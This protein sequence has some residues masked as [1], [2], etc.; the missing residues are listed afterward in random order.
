[1]ESELWET[2]DAKVGEVLQ[3]LFEAYNYFESKVQTAVKSLLESEDFTYK[4]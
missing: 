1:M 4:H 2:I 3:N